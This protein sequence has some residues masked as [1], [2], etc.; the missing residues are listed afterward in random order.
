MPRDHSQEVNGYDVGIKA[1]QKEYARGAKNTRRAKADYEGFL[2]R[3]DWCLTLL[4][5]E[6][7][8]QLVSE[9]R[10]GSGA[11]GTVKKRPRSNGVAA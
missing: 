5:R 6:Q 3:I 7:R 11:N 9:R 2:E 8:E 4:K 10:S 1:L